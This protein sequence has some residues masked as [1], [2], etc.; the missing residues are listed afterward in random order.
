[1]KTEDLKTMKL[2]V[3]MVSNYGQE[4]TREQLEIWARVL[5][6]VSYEDLSRAC[7]EILKD[8]SYVRM[9]LPAQIRAK[10]LGALSAEELKDQAR[11]VGGRIWESISRFGQWRAEDAEKALGEVAWVV[12]QRMGGWHSVCQITNSDRTTFMAQCRDLAESC[13]RSNS[14]TKLT[15]LGSKGFEIPVLPF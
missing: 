5:D 4:P 11:D 7:M 15:E 1:M 6:D 12:V 9:P 8:P 2:L 14:R 13:L 3:G 10:A